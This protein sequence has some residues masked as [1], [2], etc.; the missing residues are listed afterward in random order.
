MLPPERLVE[1]R[2]H[3]TAEERRGTEPDDGLRGF[4]RLDLAEADFERPKEL[5]AD[6]QEQPPGWRQDHVAAAGGSVE[7][8]AADDRFEHS[9]LLGDRRARDEQRGGGSRKRPLLRHSREDPELLKGQG[10]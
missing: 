2:E 10:S 3:V 5:G 6:R 9:D 4:K 7:Q 1:A 8:A